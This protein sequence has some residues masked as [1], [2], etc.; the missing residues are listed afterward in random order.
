VL[1][2]QIDRDLRDQKPGHFVNIP[3]LADFQISLE[4]AASLLEENT[5]VHPQSTEPAS[6]GADLQLPDPNVGSTAVSSPAAMPREKLFQSAWPRMIIGVMFVLE[7]FWIVF[8]VYL[9]IAFV[10]FAFLRP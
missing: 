10:R 3:S 1:A 8:L 6:L 7:V 5:E 9:S 2:D 4:H